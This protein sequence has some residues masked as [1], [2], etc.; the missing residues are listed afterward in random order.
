MKFDLPFLM[1]EFQ[2]NDLFCLL[3]DDHLG[4]AI[5][6][7]VLCKIVVRFSDL[8]PLNSYKLNDLYRY[9]TGREMEQTHRAGADV[10]ACAAVLRYKPF[11]DA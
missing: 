7:L 5:D 2:H 9:I 4:Y 6:T 1:S 3:E 11:W 8:Q 10:D